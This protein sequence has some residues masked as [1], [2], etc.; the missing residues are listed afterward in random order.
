MP[1][2]S[3]QAE[4]SSAETSAVG[5]K[6]ITAENIKKNIRVL[7]N[8]AV[9]GRLRMLS[10]APVINMMSENK[11]SLDKLVIEAFSLKEAN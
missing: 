2:F 7:P 6:K 5:I 4:D 9:A 10:I 11:L 1:L 3:G 8:R